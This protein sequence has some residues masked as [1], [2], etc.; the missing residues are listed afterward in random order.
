MVNVDLEKTSRKDTVD[1]NGDS[2]VVIVVVSCGI[3]TGDCSEIGSIDKGS[4]DKGSFFLR[5]LVIVPFFS[6][7]C[8]CR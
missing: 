5:F 2:D 3:I 1:V 6:F 8:S 7:F 4:I